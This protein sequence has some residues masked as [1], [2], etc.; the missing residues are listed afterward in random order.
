M[1]SLVRFEYTCTCYM[2]PV[3]EEFWDMGH[4]ATF[5]GSWLLIQREISNSIPPVICRCIHKYPNRTDPNIKHINM[6]CSCPSENR[7]TDVTSKITATRPW[8]KD[9]TLWVRWAN[10]AGVTPICPCKEEIRTI[11]SHTYVSWIYRNYYNWIY[12]FNLINKIQNLWKKNYLTTVHVL[13]I[14][15]VKNSNTIGCASY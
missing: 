1:F 6:Y 3:K 8:A 14:H 7:I 5:W 10:A 9:M 2:V 4:Q 13:A 11:K 15:C 12:A